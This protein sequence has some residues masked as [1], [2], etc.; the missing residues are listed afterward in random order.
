M[1]NAL[2]VDVL[3]ALVAVRLVDQL[4]VDGKLYDGQPVLAAMVPALGVAFALVLTDV[5][6][7]S[8]KGDS[9]HSQPLWNKIHLMKDAARGGQDVT[10]GAALLPF[11]CRYCNHVI[12][13][14][15]VSFIQG[16]RSVWLVCILVD[17]SHCYKPQR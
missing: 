6:A 13:F 15:P 3:V 16:D 12:Y 14:P 9:L 4:G 7:T 1:D 5:M 2:T 17:N 8:S 10:I 11:I